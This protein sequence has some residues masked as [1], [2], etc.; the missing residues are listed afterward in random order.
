MENERNEY[1][2]NQATR[3]GR[4]QNGN[5]YIEDNSCAGRTVSNHYNGGPFIRV[6]D[7]GE[8]RAVTVVAEPIE[9]KQRVQCLK[10]L[11][12]YDSNVVDRRIDDFIESGRNPPGGWEVC[13]LYEV[14]AKPPPKLLLTRLQVTKSMMPAVVSC[15][16]EKM[17]LEASISHESSCY[18][19]AMN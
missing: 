4:L 1:S 11:Q 16:G 2:R 6:Q 7:H 15:K 9:R 17:V 19:R 10:L 18:E 3:R 5:N 14:C 12:G 8:L 13:N